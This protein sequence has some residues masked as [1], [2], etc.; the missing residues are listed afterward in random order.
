MQQPTTEQHTGRSFVSWLLIFMALG[1]LAP[2]ILL[3]EWRTYQMMCMAE[4]AE[5]HR[6]DALAKVVA[7]ERRLHEATRDDP[8]VL[9]RLAQRDLGFHQIG[10][11]SVLV[12]VEPSTEPAESA[13]IP[14]PP[15]MPLMLARAAYRLPDYDYD[16]VLCN[17]QLRAV[18]LAMS[19][20]LIGVG[21]WVAPTREPAH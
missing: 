4:Q 20:G 17:P 21:L 18:V 5:Q 11:Q 8:A 13:F 6:L 3:P 2:C 19:L 14:H 16:A 7:Q 10:G 12:P 15:Q 9:V 1:T